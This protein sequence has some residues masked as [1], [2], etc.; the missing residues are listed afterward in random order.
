[1]K[2]EELERIN[3]GSQFKIAFHPARL[4]DC[5]QC[6]CGGMLAE[7]HSWGESATT[8]CCDNCSEVYFNQPTKEN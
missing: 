2:F 8:Y 3:D 4:P 5:L 6:K 1:M 7:V